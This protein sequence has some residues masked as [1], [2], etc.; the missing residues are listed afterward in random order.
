M[1]RPVAVCIIAL[2]GIVAI[3]VAGITYFNSVQWPD[4][5][6]DEPVYYHFDRGPS[7]PEPVTLDIQISV[8]S[9]NLQFVDNITLL[10]QI[11]VTVPNQTVQQAGDPTVAYDNTTKT[12]TL[13][14][15]TGS[16][17]VTLG[18]GVNYTISLET[19]TGSIDAQLSSGGTVNNVTLQT[20]TGSIDLIMTSN[21]VIDGQALF[22]LDTTTGSISSTIALPPGVEGSFEGAT[23]VGSVNVNAPGWTEITATHYQTTNYPTATTSITVL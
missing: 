12:V 3:S 20:L 17:N 5:F 8:G 16:V 15:S 19:S 9:I 18:T 2:V 4:P 13:V 7:G 14:Y 21:V 22:D 6:G 1:K 10:Y 11:D 23:T